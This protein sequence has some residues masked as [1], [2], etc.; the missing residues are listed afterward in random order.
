MRS[1]SG[2]AGRKVGGVKPSPLPVPA[3]GPLDHYDPGE[4]FY[5]EAFAGPGTPR[6]HY[7]DVLEALSDLNLEETCSELRGELA[8]R[9]VCFGGVDGLS[10][11]E[12]D[13]VPRILP[14]DEWEEIERGAVQRVRALNSFIGD[15]YGERRIVQAGRVPA[16]VIDQAEHYEP[17]M[18]GVP[19]P[20]GI[21]AHVSGLD[22]V[23][24][25]DG[26]FLVLEDNL[27]TPSGVTYAMAARAA[28]QPRLPPQ[29]ES[30]PRPL[31]VAL[32]AFAAALRDASPD[33]SGDP[34]VVM[35][36]DGPASSAWYEHKELSARLGVP[37]VRPDQL[38]ARAGVLYARIGERRRQVDVLYRR[39][40]VD[41]LTDAGGAPTWLAEA[42]LE[43]CRAGRLAV[44]N[45]FG[46][47]VADDKLAHVYVEEMIRFYLGEE[48]I[49]RSVQSHDLS[50]PAALQRALDRIEQ[51]VVKPRT[52]HG[53]YGIVICA[54]ATP[55]DRHRIAG[56]IRMEP[57]RY[58]AQ[59]LVGLSRHPT[60]I[61]GRLEPRHVDLRP[62][63]ISA[64]DEITVVPG[65]L[66]R[67]A[68]E[69]DA[70][71][72]NSSQSGGG[73]DTWVTS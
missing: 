41:G 71:V 63:V 40:D 39:T 68:F 2:G 1:G 58:V 53:G 55:S 15:A 16:R 9:G 67:V 48:P 12:V 66:T 37:L 70:L 65:G 52:G 49:L 57:E 73:K 31:D 38:E 26:R 60:V 50:N 30:D 14:A 45:A 34:S 20:R 46:A 35:V 36:S 59:E 56:L 4:E 13:P 8:R 44:V 21:Y 18:R 6:P 19:V 43:P 17:L 5:D 72:V 24:R 23:R 62:F 25:P 22:L 69:E 7:A 32:D 3:R 42:T 47:G 10:P 61:G 54:H 64:G 29:L 28:L 51:L 27:R 11:F 33:G